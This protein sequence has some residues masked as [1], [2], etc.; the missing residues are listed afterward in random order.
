[1]VGRWDSQ[2]W[3]F[4][5]PKRVLKSLEVMHHSDEEGK[6]ICR[7]GIYESTRTGTGGDREEALITI[8]R[9]YQAELND[10]I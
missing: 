9:M 6:W 1:M 2:R 8:A 5:T 4:K 7:I 10:L 3:F